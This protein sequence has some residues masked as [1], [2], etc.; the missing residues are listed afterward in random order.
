MSD[1]CHSFP[2]RSQ[3]S[4]DSVFDDAAPYTDGA[5]AASLS[6]AA[7]DDSDSDDVSGT[8]YRT[9]AGKP[10]PNPKFDFFKH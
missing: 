1:R 9:V 4:D 10:T 3:T 8:D 2:H 7:L 6:V 5:E